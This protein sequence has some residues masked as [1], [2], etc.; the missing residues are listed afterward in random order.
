MKESIRFALKSYFAGFLGCL[1]ALSVIAILALIIGLIFGSQIMSFIPNF[2]QTSPQTGF[3]APN[4]SEPDQP[5]DIINSDTVSKLDMEI[6]L[7]EGNDP[8]GEHLTTFSSAQTKDIH[9]WVKPPQEIALEFIIMITLP[10]SS[11]SQFGPRFLSDTSGEPMNCGQFSEANPPL[12]EYK[13]EIIPS[14][15]PNPV[16]SLIFTIT[17]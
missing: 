3:Q 8:T 2:F 7:T 5:D 16:A 10:N 17:E 6:Y 1:G 15:D 12:G 13:L 14:M 4:I 11:Q 9:C